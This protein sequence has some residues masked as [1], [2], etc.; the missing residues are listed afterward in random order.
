LLVGMAI[1]LIGIIAMF[2][3][4]SMWDKMQ[5]TTAAGSDAQIAGTV[6]YFRLERD[7]KQAGMG[8]AKS[9]VMG[10]DVS[11]LVNA[12]ATTTARA[13][14][15][16]PLVPVQIIRASRRSPTSLQVLI[17]QFRLLRCRAAFQGLDGEQQED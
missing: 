9:T 1:G 10:C 5:R 17:W 4:L 6:G 12:T 3:V 2:Q 7:L 14:F 8:F 15:T 16:F 11:A 13:A